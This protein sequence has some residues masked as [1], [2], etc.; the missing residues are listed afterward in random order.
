MGK[1][2]LRLPMLISV[3]CSHVSKLL[4]YREGWYDFTANWVLGPQGGIQRELNHVG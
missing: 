1:V 2:V 4:R 3:L